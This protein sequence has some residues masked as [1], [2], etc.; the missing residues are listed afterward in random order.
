MNLSRLQA[1]LAFVGRLLIAYIFLAS[2]WSKIGG[3]AGT[4]QYMESAGLPGTLLPLVI[5]LELAGGILIVI[6]LATSWAA[7]ALAGFTFLSAFFF[8]F[9]FSDQAQVINFNKNLA[10]AGG[11]LILAAFGPGAW[12][13]EAKRNGRAS[14]LAASRSRR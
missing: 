5:L 14:S 13:L 8:H 3:Y 11:F 2:G 10:I 1:P 9:D 12:S 7:L 6:G 4:A